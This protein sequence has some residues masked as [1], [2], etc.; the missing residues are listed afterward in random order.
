MFYYNYRRNYIYVK[1]KSNRRALQPGSSKD[2]PAESAN[3]TPRPG[4]NNKK[5][6]AIVM[7][8]SPG[9]PTA[10]P[11]EFRL[12]PVPDVARRHAEA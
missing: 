11:L 6:G 8:Q 5:R 3:I 7:P 1:I 9:G 12:Q 10:R 4:A 2:E